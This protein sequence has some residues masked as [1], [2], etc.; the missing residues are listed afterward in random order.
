MW[1]YI[2]YFLRKRVI[3][4]V[5]KPTTL[6]NQYIYSESNDIQDIPAKIVARKRE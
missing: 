6:T 3:H 5:G 1:L 4:I 2:S